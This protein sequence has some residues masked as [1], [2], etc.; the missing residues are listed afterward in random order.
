MPNGEPTGAGAPKAGG[1]TLEQRLSIF[2]SIGKSLEDLVGAVKTIPSAIKEAAYYTYYTTKA[3]LGLTAGCLMTGSL[4]A[5]VFPLG[6]AIG[7]GGGALIK[8]EKITY[9]KITN[10]LSIGGILSGPLHYIFLGSNYLGKLV[11]S[12]YGTVASLIT[13]GGCA[14]AQIPPF[15]AMH[16]Y[17]NRALMK[18]YKPKPLKDM[19]KQIKGPIKWLIPPLIANFTV[20]PPAYQMPVAAGISVAYGLLKTESKKEEKKEISPYGLPQGYALP[21][22]A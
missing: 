19:F 6:M 15:L 8:G 22:A 7:A 16:E 12:A 20:V 4:Q 17:L 3:A 5:L 9:K 2:D 18:D 21:K 10:E 13:R 1:T 11:K 14:L